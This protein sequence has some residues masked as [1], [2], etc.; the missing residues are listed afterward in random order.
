VC[1]ASTISEPLGFSVAETRS[2]SNQKVSLLR[3]R[4]DL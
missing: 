2:G 4:F 1:V 3:D